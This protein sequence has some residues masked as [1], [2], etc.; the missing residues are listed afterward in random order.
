MKHLTAPDIL[1]PHMTDKVVE[2]KHIQSFETPM[3]CSM[4]GQPITEGVAI[5][6][7]VSIA[8]NDY[9]ETFNPGQPYV[10]VNVAQVFKNDWNLGSVVASPSHYVKPLV[11][12]TNATEERPQWATLVRA[13][14]HWP[15]D[16]PVVILFATDTKKRFWPSAK[17]GYI[18]EKT[19]VLLADSGSAIMRVIYVSWPKL[20]ACLDLVQSIRSIG[21]DR[22]GGMR[23]AFPFSENNLFADGL[24]VSK[25]G[26]DKAK[27]LHNQL[28]PWYHTNELLL[29]SFIEGY[30]LHANNSI[31]QDTPAKP[32]GKRG[33]PSANRKNDDIP[34]V[35]D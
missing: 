2:S 22:V 32:K 34:P 11:A 25:V 21:F 29:V 17:L 28:E 3:Y 24:T 20:L 5:D 4:T 8:F 19:P 13:M 15:K 16:E 14:A 26:F 18:G 27:E 30:S 23:R 35:N 33:R 6:D 10:S 12:S 1:A 31:S 9:V 7:C